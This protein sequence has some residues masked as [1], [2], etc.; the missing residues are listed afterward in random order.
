LRRAICVGVSR[1]E[2]RELNQLAESVNRMTERL[3]EEQ[4]HLVR[5]EK[6]AS[7]GRLAGGHRAR[8]RQS[9]GAAQWLQPHPARSRRQ[10]PPRSKR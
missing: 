4:A 9:V 6:L 2:S 3:L 8:D 10:R 1:H 5:A 7:V